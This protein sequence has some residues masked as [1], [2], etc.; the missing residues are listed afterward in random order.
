LHITV[1]DVFFKVEGCCAT[2]PDYIG[3]AMVAARAKLFCLN[4]IVTFGFLV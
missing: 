1:L 4:L 3:N 2:W